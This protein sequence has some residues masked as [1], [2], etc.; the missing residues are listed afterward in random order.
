MMSVLYRKIWILFAQV[1]VRRQK[2]P[3]GTFSER[4]VYRCGETAVPEKWG[5]SFKSLRTEFCVRVLKY[6]ANGAVLS[7]YTERMAEIM[8]KDK[9]ALKVCEQ[10]GYNYKPTPAIMLKGAWLEDG[11][12]TKDTPVT[13]LV[14]EGNDMVK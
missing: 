7:K 3:E 14:E 2:H 4:W 9:W 12:F 1:K 11:V 8:K 5:Q 13:V 10:S 6:R